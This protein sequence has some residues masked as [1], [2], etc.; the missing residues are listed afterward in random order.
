MNFT[1]GSIRFRI[2]ELSEPFPADY[3]EKFAE[4]AAKSLEGL[5]EDTLEYGWVTSRHLLDANIEN[6][7][8]EEDGYVHLVLRV[9]QRKIPKKLFAAECKM[10]EMAYMSAEG[11]S[12]LKNSEKHE[13]AESVLD[14]MIS[15][16]LPH[17]N[18]IPFVTK[19]GSTRLFVGATS[20]GAMDNFMNLLTQTIMPITGLCVTPEL[21]GYWLCNVDLRDYDGSTFSPEL[22][23]VP[24]EPQPG[25][26]FFTWLWF[27][28]ESHSGMIHIT[29][30]TK[31]TCPVQDTVGVLI[32]GPL[33]FSGIGTGAHL[34]I[35]KN[36][37][38]TG[39]LEAKSCLLA[40]KKLQS[41]TVTFA[42]SDEVRIQFRFDA[43]SFVFSGMQFP[44][45][46]RGAAP[47]DAFRLRM[48]QLDKWQR[49]F[50][51]LFHMFT[52]IRTNA[53]SW[54]AERKKIV[55]WVSNRLELK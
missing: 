42:F 19:I 43:A 22:L 14:R 28:A 31:E 44:K 5:K 7:I 51:A 23:D 46:E 20:L 49:T 54:K 12:W 4:R 25:C 2:L 13:I 34:G 37:S 21:L 33:V 53:E 10:E 26:E 9:A 41:A 8:G 38:P 6:Y 15:T 3:L 55:E 30:V 16:A 1:K 45:P 27:M 39:S 18:G 24:V 29:E 40:G 52:L 11:R 48:L 35:I 50:Y 47:S 32:E 36:G 17:I